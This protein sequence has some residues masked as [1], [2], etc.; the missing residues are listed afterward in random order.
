MK[1]IPEVLEAKFNIS[2]RGV[3][4]SY[5]S[6]LKAT[7]DLKLALISDALVVTSRGRVTCV[8][9]LPNVAY[10]IPAVAKAEAKK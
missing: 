8:V 2:V 1:D 6:Q 5:A 7:D 9:P 4:N 3:G 10:V